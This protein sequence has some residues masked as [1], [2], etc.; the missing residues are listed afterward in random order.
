MSG[1]RGVFS[2]PTEYFQGINFNHRVQ[3]NTSPRTS[4]PV[5]IQKNR[6]CVCAVGAATSRNPPVVPVSYTGR[7][8]TSK[9]SGWCLSVKPPAQHSLQSNCNTPHLS[10]QTTFFSQDKKLKNKT[11]NALLIQVQLRNI[12]FIT[13]V[14]PRALVK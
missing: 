4:S 1:L 14:N 13:A 11:K 12:T 8:S 9:K 5:H 7:Q 10:C 3:N 6:T 2:A